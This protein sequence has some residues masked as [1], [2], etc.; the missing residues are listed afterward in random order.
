MAEI[1]KAGYFTKI[2]GN[3]GEN[4]VC[5]WLARSGFEVALVDSGTGTQFRSTLNK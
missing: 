1:I 3:F 2:I 4:M 5:N